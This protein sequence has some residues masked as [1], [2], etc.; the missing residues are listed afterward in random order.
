MEQVCGLADYLIYSFFFFKQD[1]EKKYL[2][3]TDWDK[4]KKQQFQ[5]FIY[6]INQPYLRITESSF[7]N[8]SI[9]DREYLVAL[10]GDKTFPDGSYII[11][12]LEDIIQYQKDFMEVCSQVRNDT[13]FTFPVKI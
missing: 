9:Y 4:Y 12:Y 8:I 1:K 3:I 6:N 10:F 7:S 11:D 13:M 5:A 2:G